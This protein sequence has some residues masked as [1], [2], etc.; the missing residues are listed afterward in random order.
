MPTKGTARA[1]GHNL[2]ANEGTDI[3]ARGQAV[4]RT[5]IAIGLPDNTYAR[6]APR[7]ILAV[8]HRLKAN[9]GLIDSPYRGEMKVVLANLGDQPYRVEKGDRIAQLII[10]KSKTEN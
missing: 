6:I 4:V 2:Y 8:E 10:K 7:S 3:R 5:G 1:A 9:A